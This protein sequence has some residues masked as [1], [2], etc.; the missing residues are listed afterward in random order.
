MT[1]AT[2]PFQ[3]F[4][5]RCVWTVT[6]NVQV[7]NEVHSSNATDRMRHNIR[8]VKLTPAS[9]PGYKIGLPVKGLT[10][11]A[12]SAFTLLVGWPAGHHFTCKNLC[13]IILQCFDAVGWVRGKAS[14]A[15]KKISLQHPLISR[16]KL[17]NP[18]ARF[19]DNVLRF[20]HMIY[21]V[22]KVMMC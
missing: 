21:A 14:I 18:G 16:R 10:C 11:E 9:H 12:F 6:G 22:T 4:V 7:K 3:K 2:P 15:C 5:M 13:P 20:Y 8:G 17:A 19:T 1:L